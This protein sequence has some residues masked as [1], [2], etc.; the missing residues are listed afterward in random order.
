MRIG[1]A[2]KGGAGK[3]TVAA[4]MARLFARRGFDVNALDGDPNPNFASALGLGAGETARLTRVPREGVMEERIGPGDEAS[5]HLTR[6]LDEIVRTYGAIG[7]DGVRM[8]TMTGLL[9]AGK[10]C[11]CGQHGM[12]REFV[13]TLGTVRPDDVTILDTEASL[14]HMSRA[15]VGTVDTLLIV[16]EPYFRALQTLGRTVPLARELEIPNVYAVANKVRSDWDTTT[17]REYADRLGVEVLGEVPYDEAV[18]KADR[19][20]RSLLDSE[21]GSPAVQAIDAMVDALIAKPVRDATG[22]ARTSA[23]TAAR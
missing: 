17:I 4:T 2:G 12:V 7:P 5:L 1:V 22:E 9:G 23:S 18:A 10:G 13:D 3:T 14:E 15:T 19:E 16:V 8:L 11:I 21:P 20:N 6:P